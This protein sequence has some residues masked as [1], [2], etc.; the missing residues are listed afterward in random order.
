LPDALQEADRSLIEA[1]VPSHAY[2]DVLR[3][4]QAGMVAL[5]GDT[6][7]DDQELAA[8]YREKP[9]RVQN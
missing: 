4:L 7:K 6:C 8:F 3:G 2:P 1:Q 9:R 5:S